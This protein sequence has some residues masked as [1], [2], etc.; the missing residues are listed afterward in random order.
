MK[1]KISNFLDRGEALKKKIN[2][3]NGYEVNK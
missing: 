1:N 2:D 3:V